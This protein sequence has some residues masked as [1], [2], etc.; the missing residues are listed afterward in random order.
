MT[1]QVFL[2]RLKSGYSLRY[3][4]LA[5]APLARLRDEAP[6]TPG[7]GKRRLITPLREHPAFRLSVNTD[8]LSDQ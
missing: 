7:Y 2:F 8:V 5:Q 4:S 3:G 1:R 6:R